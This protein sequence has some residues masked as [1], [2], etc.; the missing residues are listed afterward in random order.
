[1]V[2]LSEGLDISF[3]KYVIMCTEIDFNDIAYV[4]LRHLC[5]YENHGSE[6]AV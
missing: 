1:M 2:G 4:K 6:L 3:L 5:A